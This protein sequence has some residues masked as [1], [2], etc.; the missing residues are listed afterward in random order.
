MNSLDPRK[1]AWHPL[2]SSKLQD[3]G[4]GVP[5]GHSFLPASRRLSHFLGKRGS[6]PPHLTAP[7]APTPAMTL[8]AQARAFS[9]S[10][11][12]SGS[13]SATRSSG[14]DEETARRVP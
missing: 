10:G 4:K 6:C 7:L 11:L 2:S 5:M 9:L 3:G 14:P 13:W 8:G 12:L 1:Q